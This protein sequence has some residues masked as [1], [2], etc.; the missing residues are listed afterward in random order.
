MDR[1]QIIKALECCTSADKYVSDYSKGIRRD[2]TCREPVYDPAEIN[3]CLDCKE[4][5]CSGYCKK[6]PK[7]GGRKT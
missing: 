6:F 3:I 1:E 7:S 2:S 5:K 4:I